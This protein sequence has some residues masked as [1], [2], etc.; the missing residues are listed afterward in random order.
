MWKQ[1]ARCDDLTDLEGPILQLLSSRSPVVLLD[2][3]LNIRSRSRDCHARKRLLD[4]PN[5]QLPS[6]LPICPDLGTLRKLRWV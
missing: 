3:D 4:Q 1:K 6:S 5:S 2:A